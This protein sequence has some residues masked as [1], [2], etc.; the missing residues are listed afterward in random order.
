MTEKEN[1][2]P[3]TDT[4]N[5]SLEEKLLHIETILNDVVSYINTLER[6][7]NLAFKPPTKEEDNNGEQNKPEKDTDGHAEGDKD[8]KSKTISVDEEARGDSKE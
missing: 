8:N 4:R 5:K 6:W 1:S 2:T 7:R 3:C